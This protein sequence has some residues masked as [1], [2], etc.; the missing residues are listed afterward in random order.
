MGN[1]VRAVATKGKRP[2]R[3]GAT[4]V[5]HAEILDFVR[6][7][8]AD[9]GIDL[10]IEIFESFDEPNELLVAGRLQANF[11]QYRPFLD[12]FNRLTGNAL[13]PVVPVHTEPF[14]LYSMTVTAVEAIPR[15]AEIALPSDPVNV[16]RSLRMLT[17][18]GLITRDPVGFATV[19][20]VRENPR[21]LLF[22]QLS[23]W[24]LAE[25]RAD[26][27]V[28]FLFGNQAMEWGVDIGSALHCDQGNSAYAEYLVAR[29]DNCDSYPVRALADALNREQTRDFI[30][31][32]YAGQ[33]LP[34]F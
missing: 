9:C 18:L 8:L 5:P 16:D 22:K 15:Y 31:T 24:T 12:N 27:D 25:V 34:A 32:T 4:P 14:G 30:L 3:V 17:E 1:S 13:V 2:L 23:S 11:F 20:N 10:Q 7:P 33:V 19:Y 6:D 26:F 21:A 28:V 29:P